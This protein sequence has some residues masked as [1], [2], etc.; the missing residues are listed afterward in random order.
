MK[1]KILI[2]IGSSIALTALIYLVF[3]LFD[4]FSRAS[5]DNELDAIKFSAIVG[6]LSAAYMVFLTRFFNKPRE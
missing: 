3:L 1:R 4:V 5:R 6:T 2:F